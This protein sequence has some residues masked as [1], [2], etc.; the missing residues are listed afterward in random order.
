MDKGRAK[1]REELAEAQADVRAL[2]LLLAE[3]KE[4]AENEMHTHSDSAN[5]M[6]DPYACG[7]TDAMHSALTRP[8][9]EQVLAF[10]K[11][12]ALKKEQKG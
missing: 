12:L 7:I 8:G 9:V 5:C 1:L 10:R 3:I 6:W 4:T 2:A 11:A